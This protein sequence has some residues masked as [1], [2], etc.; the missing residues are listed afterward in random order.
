MQRNIFPIWGG[1]LAVLAGG[2]AAADKPK[3]DGAL[4]Q[5]AIQAAEAAAGLPPRLLASIGA[6]ESGRLDPGTGRVTPW[7]WTINVGGAGSYFATKAEAVAA[8]ERARA[9]GQRSIDVGCMQV[10]LLHHPAAFASL[11]HAFDPQANAAYAAGFLRRLQG[12]TGTWPAAAAAYH[13]QTPGVADGY[14]RRV[15]AAWP[16][17]NQY[18]GKAAAPAPPGRTVD[19]HDIYTPEFRAR[20]QQDAADRD[21]RVAL[22]LVPTRPVAPGR[23][24]GTVA[25]G[26]ASV[27]AS[28]RRPADRLRG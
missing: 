3:W 27:T 6:V 14:A 23:T 25:T 5:S 13:S 26:R 16:L 22:G 11:N 8:V 24:S 7:P 12:Q 19:P 21:A 28:P 1:L 2:P 15:M 10:N 9:A 4:C 20:L 17:A 18:G